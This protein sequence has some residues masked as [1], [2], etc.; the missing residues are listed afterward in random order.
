MRRAAWWGVAFALLLVVPLADARMVVS[1]K[2]LVIAP[3]DLGTFSIELFNTES[4][5]VRFAVELRAAGLNASVEPPAA[6]IPAGSSAVL[7]GRV[8]SVAAT[9]RNVTVDVVLY[10]RNSPDPVE[11]QQIV[12]R[13]V[14]TESPVVADAP[15]LRLLGG[16]A[17]GAGV[18]ALVAFA[19]SRKWHLIAAAMYTRLRREALGEHPSRARMLEIVR[20]SPGIM[21]SD[22]Q[23]RSGLAN[24][25]F[26][27]HV[28]K[29]VEGRRLVVLE[30][31]RSRFVRLPGFAPVLQPGTTAGA[32]EAFVREHGQVGAAELA[33]ALELSRQVV[34]YHVHQ[35]SKEGRIAA[36][37]VRGRVV[38]YVP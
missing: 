3:G 27:H 9:A 18:G 22:L 20:D 2:E 34:H 33:R 16:L 26:E 12:V 17:A 31:G 24:G 35:L 7:E 10:E 37:L 5:P 19:L 6:I 8:S 11:V 32:I 15:P 36:R 28:K 23:A 14:T 29:L 4:A 25:P 21:L 13:V 38:L 1:P 30:E